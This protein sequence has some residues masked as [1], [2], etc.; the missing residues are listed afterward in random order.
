M[1]P[2]INR[3]TLTRNANPQ[4]KQIS[5]GKNPRSATVKRGK[6]ERGKELFQEGTECIYAE[7]GCEVNLSTHVTTAN[8]PKSGDSLL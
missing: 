7:R 2:T 1:W 6:S 8:A 3:S 4:M 5:P